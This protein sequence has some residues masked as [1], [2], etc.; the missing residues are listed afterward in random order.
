VSA[1]STLLALLALG[2]VSWN[3][4]DAALF[5]DYERVPNHYDPKLHASLNYLM[6]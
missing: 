4:A 6:I 3:I 1:P 5:L 2:H